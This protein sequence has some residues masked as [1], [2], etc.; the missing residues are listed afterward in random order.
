MQAHVAPGKTGSAWLRPTLLGAQVE[1]DALAD[2]PAEP[3][4]ALENESADSD[5]LDI[6]IDDEEIDPHSAVLGGDGRQQVRSQVSGFVTRIC[7][8]ALCR[9]SRVH[10]IR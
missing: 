2:A 4:L 3:A 7:S 9:R 1:P 6:E 5:I 10:A 8:T